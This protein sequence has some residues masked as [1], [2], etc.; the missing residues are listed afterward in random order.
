MTDKNTI[1]RLIYRDGELLDAN[2]LTHEQQ[3]HINQRQQQTRALFTPGVLSGLGVS[4]NETHISLSSGL[5]I[6]SKGRQ[7]ALVSKGQF[8]NTQIEA[9]EHGVFSIPLNDLTGEN[10]RIYIEYGYEQNS[11][12]N[13]Q[14]SC[15]KII[16]LG[17][18]KKAPEEAISLSRD[19]RFAQ[20]KTEFLPYQTEPKAGSN[21][22]FSDGKPAKELGK[23]DDSCFDKINNDLYLKTSA[24]WQLQGNLK[25]LEG[26]QGDT[27]APGEKGEKGEQGPAGN[28][29][30]SDSGLF[31]RV[32][33][34]HLETPII[35]IEYYSPQQHGGLYGNIYRIYI[36]SNYS[37]S[38]LIT[39]SP[40]GQLIDSNLLVKQLGCQTII[41]NAPYHKGNYRL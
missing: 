3:Y 22:L 12:D 18:E 8:G 40:R 37:D 28:C 10:S 32:D 24:G 34:E 1:E 5:A 36:G 16:L 39:T 25:G 31:R 4:F 15:P 20:L 38:S 14:T 6:D 35:G 41:K 23:E 21:I 2:D 13:R 30:V 26:A 7:I 29:G 17:A 33:N 11:D 9:D 19:D 27:G